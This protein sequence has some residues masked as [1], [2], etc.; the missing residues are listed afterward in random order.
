[1]SKKMFGFFIV[2]LLISV[3]LCACTDQ[4]QELASLAD[5]QQIIKVSPM[6]KRVKYI[7]PAEE[8][9][10]QTNGPKSESKHLHYSGP[11]GR[12]Q[13]ALTFDDGPDQKYT[14]QILTILK[15]NQVRATFFV[16]G[17][18]VKAHPDMLKRIHHEGHIIGNHSWGHP[19]LS[20]LS[21]QQV[22]QEMNQTNHAVKQLI[23]KEMRLM[24]P[25]Y[26]AVKGKVDLLEQM[27]YE[28]IQWNIDTLDWKKGRT[29]EDIINTVK[30]NLA[31]GS[32]ILEHN[33]GGSRTE[34]VKSL[35]HLI[36]YLRQQ[37]YQ[38]VTI[39]EML[40]VPAYK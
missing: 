27:G 19:S 14:D 36:E 32:I 5:H 29:A 40:Q 16:V 17:R 31:P 34:T 8:T 21:D 23:G 38:F 26:G 35:P 13:V 12:K 33:G 37:G 18:Q 3:V 4:N 39:D 15:K 24:R 22:A 30:S 6:P 11:N 2:S 28:M 9:A 25:P 20:Q 10:L 7:P 1:M